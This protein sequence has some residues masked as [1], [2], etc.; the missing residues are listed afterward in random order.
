MNELPE[1]DYLKSKL[2]Y[3]HE[4]GIFKWKIWTCRIPKGGIAGSIK[5]NGYLQIR[6]DNKIYLAHR[7]AWKIVYGN[8]PVCEIDHVD[9]DKLNNRISNLREVTHQEN[10]LN[11]KASL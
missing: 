10:C 4:T 8:D 11:R 9:R 1:T 5:S 6:L 2:D 3:D 7:L